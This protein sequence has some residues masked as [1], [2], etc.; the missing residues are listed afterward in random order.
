ML[1]EHPS[2]VQRLYNLAPI[3]R[4]PQA[5]ADGKHFDID[6]V[7]A[8]GPDG[9][10]VRYPRYWLRRALDDGAAF[11]DD[12]LSSAFDALD[13]LLQRPDL[14]LELR[15]EEGD[16]LFVNN[17]RVLHGRRA[18]TDPPDARGRLLLRA[19]ID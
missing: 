4:H 2:L 19:L 5:D 13:A 14:C 8:P 15:L 10:R 16:V 12:E 3:A 6:R 7:F 9:F 1:E 17:T 11:A 18:F